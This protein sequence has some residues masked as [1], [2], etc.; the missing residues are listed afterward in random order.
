M[1]DIINRLKAALM[2]RKAEEKPQM[3]KKFYQDLAQLLKTDAN[4]LK[5]FEDSYN[6]MVLNTVSENFFEVN[7]KQAVAQRE[8]KLTETEQNQ[9]VE[10]IVNELLAQ[11]AWYS[12]DGKTVASG[13]EV[14]P[15]TAKPVE[16]EELLCIPEEM[17]PQL[18]GRYMTVDIDAPSYA[19]ILNYYMQYARNPNSKQ[20]RDA[21]NRFRQGLDVLDLDQVTY[22]IISNNS[23]SIGHWLPAL[24]LGIANQNFFK[25][26][27]TTVIQVPIT[28]LQLTHLDW[29][30]LTPM[31]MAIVD[32]YCQKAF[33]LD[34]NKEYFVKTGTFSSKYDFR[35]AHVKGAKEV[36]ELGEY[37]LFIHYQALQMAAPTAQPCI[38]GV[39]TTNEWVVR[40]FIQ[41]KE[42]NPCIYKGMPLHTEYRVFVDFDTM[43]VIGCNPYWDPEVMKK[44]FSEE[45]D[46]DS[47]HQKHDYVIYM[48]HEEKLMQRYHQNVSHVVENIEKML[49]DI[50]LDGQ[51]SI[52]IMQNG[53]DFYIIDMARATESALLKCVPKNLLKPN[54]EDWLAKLPSL[55]EAEV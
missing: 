8:T 16:R 17:R 22:K 13:K 28:L 55:F 29:D 42:N 35:N 14:E 25:I 37:L 36:R 31:T 7:A 48:M 15:L 24:D 4:A 45:N 46:A 26:P 39:S 12:T 51:W 40:D 47:P 6:K 33:H 32:R 38:Y 3:P 50:L 9:I 20:G 11:T 41:D 53:D 2:F 1:F 49:P 43:K 21:Y 44:R 30:R 34:E 18:T 19:L 27:A 23:N 5:L 54:K 10:R 52:D